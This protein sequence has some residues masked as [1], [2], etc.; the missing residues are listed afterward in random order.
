[1]NAVRRFPVVACLLVLASLAFAA[2]SAFAAEIP[3][4]RTSGVFTVPVRLN[5]IMDLDFVLDSGAT[6]VT[7]PAGVARALVESGTATPDDLLPSATYML[8]DGRTVEHPRINIR[9]LEVA[10]IRVRNVAA[11]IGQNDNVML[12]GQS[13][14]ERLGTWSLDSRRSVMIVDPELVMQEAPVEAGGDPR[15]ATAL[16]EA[17]VQYQVDPDGDYVV[18]LPLTEGRTQ[19]L[20][21]NSATRKD[22]AG[23]EVRE[24][25]SPAFQV[26]EPELPTEIRSLADRLLKQAVAFAGLWREIPVGE[27]AFAI[28]STTTEA[29]CDGKTL[30]EAL[31]AVSTVAD[32]MELQL[33]GG[34]LF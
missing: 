3:L 29:D 11:S 16:Q 22:Q 14:L 25:W 28:F 33:T 24:I 7:I 21:V 13:F 20:F 26:G 19:L 23:A 1:M 12:L 32:A 17:G 10:G 27:T 34:D 9:V 30:T 8:A 2:P 4:E 15:V 6:E 31:K 5:G 18:I